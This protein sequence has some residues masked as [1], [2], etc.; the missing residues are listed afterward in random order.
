[1]QML[2]HSSRSRSN[3]YVRTCRKALYTTTCPPVDTNCNK[4]TN[5]LAVANEPSSFSQSIT[6]RLSTGRCNSS[7]RAFDPVI[8]SEVDAI[9]SFCVILLQLSLSFSLLHLLLLLLSNVELLTMSIE[10]LPLVVATDVLIIA[11]LSLSSSR[12]LILLSR[13]CV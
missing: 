9:F 3:S 13:I 2:I 11:L 5:R 10:L 4:S 8:H 1:M 12:T 6:M 7:Y